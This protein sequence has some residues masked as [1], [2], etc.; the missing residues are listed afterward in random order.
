VSWHNWGRAVPRGGVRRPLFVQATVTGDTANV[1][2]LIGVP[3]QR[4]GIAEAAS[5]VRDW[6]STQGVRRLTAHIQSDHVASGRVAR[7]LGLVATGDLDSGGEQI[8]SASAHRRERPGR[9]ASVS[10]RSCRGGSTR[11]V[12]GAS[13]K[14]RHSSSYGDGA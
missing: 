5:A 8:W 12:L 3:W 7:R 2:W 13:V 6:L 10:P 9:E 14:R 11:A 4:E 1:A